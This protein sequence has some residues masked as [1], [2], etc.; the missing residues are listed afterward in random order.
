M[1]KKVK[2]RRTKGKR[3]KKNK[4]LPDETKKNEN[5]IDIL[6]MVRQINLDN[7]GISTKFESINGHEDSSSKKVHNDPEYATTKKRKAGEASPVPV[8]KRK[9]SSAVYGSLRSPSSISKASQRVS[10]D[11]PEAKS[12]DDEV[13]PVR[14][15]KTVQRKVFKGSDSDLLVSL[16]QK[17][18]GSDTYDDDEANN[19]DEHGSKVRSYFQVLYAI[20]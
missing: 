2:N 17:A 20:A 16:K 9:R 6:N 4:S 1:G 11:S 8:P 15:S 14:D 12:L 10:K 3:V 19:S 13:S 5:D 7:L 18:K